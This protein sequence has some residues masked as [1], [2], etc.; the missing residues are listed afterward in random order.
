M[1]CHQ[2]I[3]KLQPCDICGQD[4]RLINGICSSDFCQQHAEANVIYL[5]P[6]PQV[7]QCYATKRKHNKPMATKREGMERVS[8]EMV[9]RI[10][11]NT[12]AFVVRTPR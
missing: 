2:S 12:E 5:E 8:E 11:R 4:S 3:N 7:K 1:T 9:N 6:L 10:L